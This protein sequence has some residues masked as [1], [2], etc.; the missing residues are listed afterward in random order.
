LALNYPPEQRLSSPGNLRIN[1][2]RFPGRVNDKSD[3]QGGVLLRT[4]G[5]PLVLIQ[6]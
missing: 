3:E 4:A 6:P 5:Y 2:C 1:G